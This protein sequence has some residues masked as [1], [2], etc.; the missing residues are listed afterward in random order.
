[1]PRWS[2]LWIGIGLV[3]ALLHLLVT[4]YRPALSESNVAINSLKET[5]LVGRVK[6]K[7]RP[8]APTE[9]ICL[10]N[11]Y[12]LQADTHYCAGFDGLPVAAK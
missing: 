7:S 6:P 1:M 3:F 4:D 9:P 2:F 12:L 10:E 5:S 11:H 8:I